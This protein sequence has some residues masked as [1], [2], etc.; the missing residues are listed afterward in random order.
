MCGLGWCQFVKSMLYFH[1][2]GFLVLCLVYLEAV[3]KTDTEFR[4]KFRL[5]WPTSHS[6]AY[7]MVNRVAIGVD[8]VLY[9]TKIT[10][11]L[12]GFEV[13]TCF[14]LHLML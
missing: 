3:K 1:M 4:C 8:I 10:P 2:I 5:L 13:V 14:I 11:E 6:V 7:V 9:T 12:L